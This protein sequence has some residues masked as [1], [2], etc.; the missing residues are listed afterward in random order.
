MNHLQKAWL[1]ALGPVVTLVNDKMAKRSGLIG[2][3]GKFFAFGPRQ[4]GYH[5]INRYL[6]LINRIYLQSIPLALHRYS[7]IKYLTSNLGILTKM[8]ILAPGLMPSHLL[9]A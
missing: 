9:W 8:V 6:A 3:L 4:F 5:P 2:K 1:K 7:F